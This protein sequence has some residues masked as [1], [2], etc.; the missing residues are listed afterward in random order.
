MAVIG[1][2]HHHG[3]QV[4]PLKHLPVVRVTVHVVKC[5][6]FAN[7]LFLKRAHS[8]NLRE[9]VIRVNL[10]IVP[11]H[12]A[13]TDHANTHSFHHPSFLPSTRF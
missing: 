9:W 3:I 8:S 1:S 12:R 13:Q 5:A 2:C 4:L 7:L 6:D 11:A 10:H